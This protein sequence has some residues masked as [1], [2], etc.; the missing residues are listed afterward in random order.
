MPPGGP[1]LSRAHHARAAEPGESGWA[2]LRASAWWRSLADA[3]ADRAPGCEQ[4]A[5]PG[6]GDMPPG[7]TQEPGPAQDAVLAEGAQGGWRADL[8]AF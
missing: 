4:D 3:A 8:S 7:A 1:A 5:R 6:T 2:Q